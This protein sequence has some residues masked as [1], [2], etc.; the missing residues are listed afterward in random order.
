MRPHLRAVPGAATIAGE[1]PPPVKL[2]REFKGLTVADLMRDEIV[3]RLPGQVCSA[4][5]H[6]ENGDWEAAERALPGHFATVLAGPGHRRPRRRAWL[7]IV[8]V[9]AVAVAVV[10]VRWLKE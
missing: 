4:L 1:P 2:R 8:A 7:A 9:A 5:E 6:V 10:V 3:R